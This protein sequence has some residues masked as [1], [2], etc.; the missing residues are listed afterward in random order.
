MNEEKKEVEFPLSDIE[1][2]R[3]ALLPLGYFIWGFDKTE[4]YYLTIKL[5]NIKAG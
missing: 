5:S 3:E 2:I 1:K 4:Q